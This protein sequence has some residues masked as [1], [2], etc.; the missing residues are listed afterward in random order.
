MRYAVRVSDASGRVTQSVRSGP[1]EETVLRDLAAEGLFVLSLRAAP[2]DRRGRGG[3]G[4]SERSVAEFT[5]GIALMIGAG[6]SV[7]DSLEVAESV[8]PAGPGRRGETGRLVAEL[9]GRV[10]TGIAF[11]H[12]VSH[13]HESFP[14]V[15][16]GLVGI[17]ERVGSLERVLGRLAAYLAGRKRMH[18]RVTGAMVYPLLV[19]GVALF[20]MAAVA[21]IVVPKAQDL[22]AQLGSELPE[23]VQ[24]LASSARTFVFG[25]AALLLVLTA[26]V[27]VMRA[28]RRRAGSA[29]RALDT[30]ALHI[31]W[32]GQFLAIREMVNL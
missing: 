31:P 29:A 20:G 13:M 8:F 6:L 11:A 15:Y 12:A 7:R 28:L 30:I 5:E 23:R 1:S 25:V 2:D 21:A 18:D 14:P 32:A 19:L 9:A 10:S 27:L 17:G 3:A 16:R 24:A 4:Y 22:F 26:A